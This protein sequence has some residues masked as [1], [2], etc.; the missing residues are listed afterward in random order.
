MVKFLPSFVGGKG[1]W[2]QRLKDLGL[3]GQQFVEFFA[4]SA[5]ITA[6]L[7][8]NSILVDIDPM[9]CQILRRFDEQIVPHIFTDV[10]YFA[11][12]SEVD[13]WKFAYC[14]QRMSFSGVFR[15]SGRGYN[16][17][18]KKG[19]KPI[20]VRSSYLEAL[21]RWKEINPVVI[22][23]SYLN[24][25]ISVCRDRVAIFDPPYKGSKA[26]Y[27]NGGMDY[28]DYWRRV[29]EATKVA[30]AVVVFDRAENLEARGYPLMG[31]RSMKVTGHYAGDV[32]A[33]AL[34]RH[35]V[36]QSPENRVIIDSKDSDIEEAATEP[37]E[38]RES[39]PKQITCSVC[40]EVFEVQRRKGRYPSKCP[41][42]RSSLGSRSVSN[43]EKPSITDTSDQK[44][45]LFGELS[46]ET[47]LGVV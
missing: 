35:G 13:W 30:A 23:D 2:I 24:L 28:D 44:S 37:Q 4:G 33:M 29:E 5:V 36:W 46:E 39:D 22:C 1:F 32:E 9:L 40:E 19:I 25:P 15:Y 34:F 8:S 11:K 16:V 26:H 14:L 20:E 10:D 31:V 41:G 12:R 7:S 47:D 42:C 3:E 17:P 27:N 45:R 21:D 43:Q 18:I 6:N 38:P